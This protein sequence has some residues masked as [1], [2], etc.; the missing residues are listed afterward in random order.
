LRKVMDQ[1]FKNFDQILKSQSRVW[2]VSQNSFLYLVFQFLFS[3][4]YNPLRLYFHS[5]V[6]GFSL[7]VFEVSWSH[8]MTCHSR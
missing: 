4:S 6:A 3:C 8:T 7:L 1:D 5:P 2:P